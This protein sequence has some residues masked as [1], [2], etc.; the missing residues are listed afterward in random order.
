[1]YAIVIITVISS[2]QLVRLSHRKLLLLLYSNPK[3][4]G[5][6]H[7]IFDD[8]EV[9]VLDAGRDRQQQQFSHQFLSKQQQQQYWRL[10]FLTV[11]SKNCYFML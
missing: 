6:I 4:T 1:M 8:S 7:L 10:H 3:L 9:E 2:W 11:H 5:F